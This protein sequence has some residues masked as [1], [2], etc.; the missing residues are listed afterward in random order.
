MVP[1]V[2]SVPY[3]ESHLGWPLNKKSEAVS[4]WPIKVK[5]SVSFGTVKYLTCKQF[6]CCC[7][8]SPC[9]SILS[10]CSSSCLS[11][12]CCLSSSL[13]EDSNEL[14]SRCFSFRLENLL[15]K[16]FRVDWGWVVTGMRLLSSLLN[17]C[18]CCCLR[19]LLFL[20]SMPL[21][22][23]SIVNGAGCSCCCCCCCC[24]KWCCC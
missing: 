17:C 3:K 12:C 15:L 9:T 19:K 5:S 11:C 2:A 24:C 16:L 8:S 13:D 23:A 6:S 22:A 7:S 14:M 1:T 4:E 10:C 20:L 18:C 21:I